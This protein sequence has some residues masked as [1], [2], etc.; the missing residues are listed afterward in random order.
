[1]ETI[2]KTEAYEKSR[3]YFTV[4]VFDYVRHEFTK[5]TVESVIHQRIPTDLFELL[6]LTDNENED[7]SY[8]PQCLAAKVIYTGL[9][10]PGESMLLG[11]SMARGDVICQ[12]DNDDQWSNE[13]LSDLLFYFK[14]YPNVVFIKDECTPFSDSKVNGLKLGYNLRMNSRTHTSG[15]FYILDDHTPA[16]ILGRTL[17]HNNS[18]MSFKKSILIK[19]SEYISG[20]THIN[21][22][23]IF[24]IG[25]LSDGSLGFLDKNLTYYRVPDKNSVIKS[26]S[27]KL[28]SK[29]IFRDNFEK[30]YQ[31]FSP[32]IDTCN[33]D[34][35]RQL[36]FNFTISSKI[37]MNLKY[38]W[39]YSLNKRD[40]FKFFLNSLREIA[41]NSILLIALLIL[42]RVFG[43]RTIKLAGWEYNDPQGQ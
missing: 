19:E 40:V 42:R 1:M 39:H 8:I 28:N 37:S 5:T 26:Y 27:Q 14:Q 6:I 30:C 36:F 32:K 7:F 21:D 20:I 4:I 24:L 11:A 23:N 34:Y 41:L 43:K 12:M 16:K 13:K 18:S 2:L 3:P 38:D 25:A 29:S 17:M 15:R 33:K 31:H 22:V 35:L 10:K 9:I